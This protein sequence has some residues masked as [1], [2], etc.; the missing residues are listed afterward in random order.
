MLSF[1]VTP[2]QSQ[3]DFGWCY[4]IT[5]MRTNTS[6]AGLVE[7]TVWAFAS[8][9]GQTHAGRARGMGFRPRYGMAW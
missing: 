3:H 6:L 9:I 5:I 7:S 1:A 2:E 8:S 4:V